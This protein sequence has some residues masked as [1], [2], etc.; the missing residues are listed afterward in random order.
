MDWTHLRPTQTNWNYNLN[1]KQ[2]PEPKLAIT[3]IYNWQGQH[4][5]WTHS[6]HTQTNWNNV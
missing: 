5:D 2:F 1:L 6:K 4:M 3:D